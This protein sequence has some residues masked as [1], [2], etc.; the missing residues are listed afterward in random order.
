M[1]KILK[2]AIILLSILLSN[3]SDNKVNI[4]TSTEDIT[5]ENLSG[6]VYGESFTAM[7]GK[8]FDIGDDSVSINITNVSGGCDSL[9]S[10]YD[11]YIS[12]TFSLQLGTYKGL[13]IIFHKD[14]ETSLNFFG[15][16]LEVSSFTD[17]TITVKIKIESGTE[18]NIEGSFTLDYCK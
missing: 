6:T 5:D 16:I 12:T 3:C 17:T 15:T 18:N 13:N 4:V 2:T 11:L 10:E 8:A 1:N 14:G 7:G 9:I